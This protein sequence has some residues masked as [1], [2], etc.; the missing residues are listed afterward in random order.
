MKKFLDISLHAEKVA[1]EWQEAMKIHIAPTNLKDW[2]LCLQ[3]LQD[4]LVEV[5]GF[6][7]KSTR[8]TI[9]ISRA[10]GEFS[11]FASDA[12]AVRV[13]LTP[14]DLDVARHFFLRYYRDGVA[15]VDHVDFETKEGHYITLSVDEWMPPVSSE[16]A[17]RRLSM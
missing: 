2:S 15:T 16:D 3:L 5:V 13:A 8:A 12:S 11:S 6:R 7:C 17:E 10:T 1:F 9:Q 14:A 4:D